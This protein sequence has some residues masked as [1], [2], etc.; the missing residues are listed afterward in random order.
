M[1]RSG[2][3]PSIPKTP[4]KAMTFQRVHEGG[5]FWKLDRSERE[6]SILRLATVVPQLVVITRTD[7]LSC[8]L[9]ER[10]LLRGLPVV[11]GTAET[12]QMP[13]RAFRSDGVST[14]IASDTYLTQQGHVEAGLVVHARIA[15]SPKEYYRR[16]EE[17]VS[18][19]HITLV[20]PEDDKPARRLINHLDKDVVIDLTDDQAIDALIDLT[21]SPLQASARTKRRFPL[22]R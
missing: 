4:Q 12:G 13:L 8:D 11:V 7:A 20:V 6:S 10:L 17:V 19:V 3:T 9:G 5:Y 16:L 21:E 18:P 2:D 14:L 22:V 15:S 1:L